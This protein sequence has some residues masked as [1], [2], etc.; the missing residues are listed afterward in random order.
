MVIGFTLDCENAERL[1]HDT[2]KAQLLA[3]L[4]GEVV[5]PILCNYANN[6]FVVTKECEIFTVPVVKKARPIINKGVVRPDGRVLPF[7]WSAYSDPRNK[8]YYENLMVEPNN[9]DRIINS[10]YEK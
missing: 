4:R 3:Y 8:E 9:I 5:E 1:N 2:M 7:G 10:K 6:N